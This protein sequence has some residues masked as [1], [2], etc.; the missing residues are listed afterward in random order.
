MSSKKTNKRLLKQGMTISK[1]L[2]FRVL[3]RRAG[4][5]ISHPYRMFTV[6]MTALN[7]FKKYEGIGQMS[8]S[9]ITSGI[10]LTQMIKAYAIGNYRGIEITKIVMMLGAIIYFIS[11]LDIV[12]D[13]IPFFGYL[14][15][16]SLLTW[17]FTTL[18]T[19]LEQ[20]ETWKKLKDNNL[21][22]ATYQ[23][24]YK[25]AQARN[26]EGRSKLTKAELIK[27]LNK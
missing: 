10:L 24:L 4:S 22:E 27:A 25:L 12:P 23:E 14:D 7:K 17:V 3:I 6:G 18:S 1:T 16:V 11:P 26:I 21:E 9:V 2:L 5:I 20:F 13:F 19:E 15:D 8:S